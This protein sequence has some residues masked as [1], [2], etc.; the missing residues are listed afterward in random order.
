MRSIFILIILV[1]SYP[2]HSQIS[3]VS[4]SSK[5][6][7]CSLDPSA[8]D[9]T[10]D[11]QLYTYEKDTSISGKICKIVKGRT[12]KHIFYK[13]KGGTYYYFLNKFI[14]IY[15][16]TAKVGDTINFDVKA[17]SKLGKTYYHDTIIQLKTV[18]VS[19]SNLNI[20]NKNTRIFK[21]K[22]FSLTDF[23][24]IP[25]PPSHYEYIE[26]I[27]YGTRFLFALNLAH[28]GGKVDMRCYQSDEVNYM[29]EW[30]KQFNLNCDYEW[31]SR[32]SI[33]QA[34]KEELHVEFINNQ[35]KISNVTTITKIRIL[36]SIGQSLYEEDIAVGDN[37]T[38]DLSY[39][40]S[41]LYCVL[42]QSKNQFKTSKLFK[43]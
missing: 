23:N 9:P 19:L 21:Y 1:F 34:R 25:S 15:N 38:I 43:L 32:S 18:L 2:I 28:V 29:N 37:S 33:S 36:S 39:F 31:K 4:N 10:Y 5:W 24:H 41:G 14:V 11:Y 16:D 8:L 27:G 17:Y 12:D 22:I 6:Y 26:N 42:V 30:W 13:E 35:I 7:Y 3:W 40:K 20:G